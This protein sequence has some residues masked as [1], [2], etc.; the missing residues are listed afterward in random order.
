[1]RC[2]T[3]GLRARLGLGGSTLPQALPVAENA[4]VSDRGA[5]ECE[6]RNVRGDGLPP[7]GDGLPPR[8]DGL[9][10]RGDIARGDCAR[11]DC[12]RGDP[13]ALALSARGDRGLPLPEPPD[14]F[15]LL[16]IDP[17][18]RGDIWGGA[19]RRPDTWDI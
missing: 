10:P 3:V 13:A 16:L 6:C 1:M 14:E 2:M 4:L 7:R 18:R 5:G 17:G 11:G 8:G 19:D 15:R 12:A 9:A